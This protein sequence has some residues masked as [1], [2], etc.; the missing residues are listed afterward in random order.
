LS[1]AYTRYGR[2]YNA[3]SIPLRLQNYGPWRSAALKRIDDF[4]PHPRQTKEPGHII[5]YAAP[6]RS[7][8][9]RRNDDS[10]PTYSIQSRSD[11]SLPSYDPFYFKNTPAFHFIRFTDTNEQSIRM[12]PTTEQDTFMDSLD[13]DEDTVLDF[14]SGNAKVVESTVLNPEVIEENALLT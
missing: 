4:R 6:K 1:E 10:L 13:S 2:F 5:A 11:D 12:N 14:S 8:L 3:R 7:Y 9:Q